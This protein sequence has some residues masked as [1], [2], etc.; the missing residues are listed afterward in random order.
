MSAKHRKSGD[1][2]TVYLPNTVHGFIERDAARQGIG[3]ATWIR[4]AALELCPPE[5]RISAGEIRARRPSPA[6]RETIAEAVAAGAAPTAHPARR[7]AEQ[8]EHAEDA[9]FDALVERSRPQVLALAAQGYRENAISAI[10]RLPY[11][12]VQHV[13]TT[14]AATQKKRRR[15]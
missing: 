14:E 3:V 15:T 11:R 9:A 2:V 4:N 13:L 6:R 8:A 5:I 10:A 7:G 12:V 1:N